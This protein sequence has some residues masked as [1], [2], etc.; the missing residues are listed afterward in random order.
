MDIT[1][2]SEVLT[3][4][5]VALLLGLHPNTVYR[6]TRSGVLPSVKVGRSRR[7]FRRDVLALLHKAA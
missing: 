5:E 2:L 7:Y 1:S 3:S 4:K 6:L